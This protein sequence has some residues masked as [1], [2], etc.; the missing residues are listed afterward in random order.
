MLL[1]DLVMDPEATIHAV[2]DFIDGL[3]SRQRWAQ[4]RRLGRDQQRVLYRKAE[5]SAIDLSHFIKAAAP[6]AEVVHDGVNTLPVAPQLRRFQKRFCRPDASGSQR[7]LGY[8]EGPLRR[9]IGPGY[10]VAVP[11]NDEA[12]WQSRGGVVVDYFQIPPGAVAD[13]WPRVVANDRGLQRY[14]YHQTRDFMRRVSDHV[15]VGAVFKRERAM[16]HYFVL[17]RRD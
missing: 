10:F 5:S 8:N 6:L 15:S 12:T 11:T 7:L 13:G 4:V 3:D 17:C 2:A 16:D 14:V 9:L 1:Q